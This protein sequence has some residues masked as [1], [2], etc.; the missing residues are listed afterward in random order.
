MPDLPG[1]TVE[2]DRE[3]LLDVIDNP[4]FQADQW[5]LYPTETTEFTKILEWYKAGTYVPWANDEV[6][7]TVPD[8]KTGKLV[9]K[10][11]TKLTELFIEIKT[12]IPTSIRLNRAVRDIPSQYIVA[13][14]K[15]PSLRQSLHQ[16]M[17]GWLLLP[18][19]AHMQPTR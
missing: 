10:K 3:M 1:S 2:G 7:V 13:G 19:K 9:T 14:N 4:D 18:T 6:T 15:K 16:E 17:P 5:K 8:V 11:S 12:R